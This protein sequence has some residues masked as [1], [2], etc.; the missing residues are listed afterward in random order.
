MW[1]VSEN[2]L[3]Q[4][5]VPSF[6]AQSMAKG[7]LFGDSAAFPL[8]LFWIHPEDSTQTAK[9]G[10]QKLTRQTRAKL[11][12]HKGLL[13]FSWWTLEGEQKEQQIAVKWLDFNH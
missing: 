1:V 2:E 12:N 13:P 7:R 10:G 9:L 4:I 8:F 11:S 3:D 5:R 6:N